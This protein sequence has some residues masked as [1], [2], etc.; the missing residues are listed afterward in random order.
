MAP[1]L[2]PIQSHCISQVKPLLCITFYVKDLLNKKVFTSGLEWSQGWCPASGSGQK[3]PQN[4]CCVGK[5]PVSICPESCLGHTQQTAVPRAE[6]ATRPVP[7]PQ[8]VEILW[9]KAVQGSVCEDHD[10]VVH[11]GRHRKPDSAAPDTQVSYMCK[12]GCKHQDSGST[13]QAPLQLVSERLADSLEESVAAVDARCYECMDESVSPPGRAH[14]GTNQLRRWT[15]TLWQ[16][17]LTWTRIFRNL[18]KTTPRSHA[19]SVGEI[20]LS[21]TRMPGIVNFPSCWCDTITINSVFRL[22]IMSLFCGIQARIS[23]MCF[24]TWS[25]TCG[26]SSVLEILKLMHSWAVLA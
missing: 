20:S 1:G 6:S 19:W 4:G 26:I 12:L 16:M 15:Y 23:V 24:L 10:L 8:T 2:L 5:G 21:P 14:C 18:S 17:L 11:M 7:L 9:S 13:V 3:V 22:L 25:K